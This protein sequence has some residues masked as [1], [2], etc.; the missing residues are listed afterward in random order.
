MEWFGKLTKWRLSEPKKL[1]VPDTHVIVVLGSPGCLLRQCN[2]PDRTNTP[3]IWGASTMIQRRPRFLPFVVRWFTGPCSVVPVSL[4]VLILMGLP[5]LSGAQQTCQPNGDV[6]QDGNVTAADALLAFQR[7]LSLVPLDDCQSTIADVFPQPSVPDGNITASDAL[8]IFRMALGLPSCLDRA[9]SSIEQ[10]PL[11]VSVF[12]EGDLRVVTAGD[13][14]LDCAAITFCEGFFDSGH[15]VI[16]EAVSDS[17]WT[18]ERWVGCDNDDGTRCTVL[19]NDNRFV[20][21]TFASTAPLELDDDVVAVQEDQL[22]GIIE[23][24]S[25]GRIVFNANTVDVDNWI[26]GDILFSN[27]FG[28]DGSMAFAQRIT[29]IDDAPD[30]VTFHTVQASLEDIFRS[31][32]FSHYGQGRISGDQQSDS[33]VLAQSADWVFPVNYSEN[34]VK[35]SGRVE[36]SLAREFDVDFSSQEVRLVGHARPRG[37]ITVEVSAMANRMGLKEL[38][39]IALPPFAIPGGP[40]VV[41]VNPYLKVFFTYDARAAGRIRTT[42]NYGMATSVG[43]HYKFRQG[44]KPIFQAQVDSGSRGGVSD[45]DVEL[46]AEA[47]LRVELQFK[48]QEFKLPSFNLPGFTI[49]EVTIVSGG[50]HVGFGPFLGVQ[51]VGGLS[52]CEVDYASVSAGLRLTVGGELELLGRAL[53]HDIPAWQREWALHTL[54]PP[55]NRPPA[56]A[57]N[58]GIGD[59]WTT[60]QTATGW[61]LVWEPPEDECGILQGFSLYRDNRQI[62]RSIATLEIIES[63]LSPG[64]EYC[65]QVAALTAHG[66]G[67]RSP[68]TCF[69]FEPYGL[70][71]L[72]CFTRAPEE[73]PATGRTES[74]RRRMAEATVWGPP[75]TKLIIQFSFRAF[76]PLSPVDEY[77]V[78][79]GSWSSFK[80][81][82]VITVGWTC[83]APE[84]AYFNTVNTWD[85]QLTTG[86]VDD[87]PGLHPVLS[88]DYFLRTPI[89]ENYTRLRATVSDSFLGHHNNPG[90]CP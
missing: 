89:F 28:A 19:I 76:P 39:S 27:G 85:T 9:P 59:L 75:G 65:Y 47:G 16:L 36:L 79:C 7:A 34:G 62:A 50:P 51:S 5:A 32:S 83:T 22:Y 71:V 31:G 13:G 17:D 14:P 44:P 23:Y 81:Q 55:G 56:A 35:V 70:D 25:D 20:S 82:E 87:P 21:V 38:G 30:R 60:D 37:S 48:I 33:P 78:D 74:V 42:M 11:K 64:N 90:G 12:G 72:G 67:D 86:H 68:P 54:Y 43:V 69:R 88:V 53:R 8:C 58:L 6:N 15:E 18:H 73:I 49:P 46:Y 77:G 3:V 57:T 40:V 84:G 1:K 66:E 26:V 2:L 10:Y 61:T 52:I 29:G 41:K 80:W 4:L 45:F 24:N 63:D